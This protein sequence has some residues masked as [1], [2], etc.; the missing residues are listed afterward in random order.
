MNQFNALGNCGVTNITFV[1]MHLTYTPGS[2]GGGYFIYTVNFTDTPSNTIY[3]EMVSVQCDYNPATN[4]FDA[5]P[6]GTL[7]ACLSQNCS[8]CCPE[9]ED[10]TVCNTTDPEKNSK[11]ERR[12]SDD[13]RPWG[14]CLETVLVDV[15]TWLLN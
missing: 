12:C 1:E 14:D 11:C 7:W 4:T 10:C 2:P 13:T 9:G 8:D 3:K 5:R 15:R 6:N